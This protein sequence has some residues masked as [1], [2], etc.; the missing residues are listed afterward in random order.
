MFSEIKKVLGD[1]APSKSIVCKW[2]LEFQH[3]Q[4]SKIINYIHDMFMKNK[5]VTKSEIA[6]NMGISSWY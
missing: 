1:T 4:A 3:G 5:I 6:G 2:A